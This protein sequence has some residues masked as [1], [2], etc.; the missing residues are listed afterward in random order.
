MPSAARCAAWMRRGELS[1]PPETLIVR[2]PLPDELGPDRV[3]FAHKITVQ[4]RFCLT[5]FRYDLTTAARP[6][7]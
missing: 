2:P 6:S 5:A 3:A 4:Q 7:A 1:E